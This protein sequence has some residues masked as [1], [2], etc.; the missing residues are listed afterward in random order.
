[1]ATI[2]GFASNIV[3]PVKVETV[4]GVEKFKVEFER[5]TR[6]Q[7]KQNIKAAK[8][9]SKRMARLESKMIEIEALE[10]ELIK[11]DGDQY[12]EIEAK[13]E[14]LNPDKVDEDMEALEKESDNDLKS[15]IK[16][17]SNLKS[18]DGSDFEFNEENLHALIDHPD[19]FGALD[20]AQYKATGAALKN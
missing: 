9:R 4:D 17:W 16:G 12:D 20:A 1:M 11:A 3:V 15:R 14:A 13:I 8:L 10:N 5:M 18:D 19:Y 2:K 6:P 7:A